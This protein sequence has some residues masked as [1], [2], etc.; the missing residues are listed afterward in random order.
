MN[1]KLSA[2]AVMLIVMIFVCLW[3]A[4]SISNAKAGCEKQGYSIAAPDGFLKWHCVR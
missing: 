4:I 1:T 3:E 2:S